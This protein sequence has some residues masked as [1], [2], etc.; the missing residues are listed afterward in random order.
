M[1]NFFGILLWV[2]LFITLREWM[3]AR[4]QG[5]AIT[6][7]EKL[8]LMLALPI[9]LAA[10]LAV[11]VAGFNPGSG[12]I[13]ALVIGVVLNGWAIKRR[14]QRVPQRRPGGWKPS[15]DPRQRTV[16]PNTR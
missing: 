14:L 3:Y 5:V 2:G 11:E 4:K 10:Q 12:T 7:P 8:A 16:L 1:R 13:A 15:I 6:L 9:G